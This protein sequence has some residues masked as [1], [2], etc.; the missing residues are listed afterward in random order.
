MSALWRRPCGGTMGLAVAHVAARLQPVQ[1]LGTCSP[2]A[3]DG[4]FHRAQPESSSFQLLT[5][6]SRGRADRAC[7]LHRGVW[8]AW[9]VA[10]QKH[11]LNP[12]PASA[13][14][15]GR[16]LTSLRRAHSSPGRPGGDVRRSGRRG[17][18]PVSWCPRVTCSGQRVG[19]ARSRSQ[20]LT[21]PA[22]VPRGKGLNPSKQQCSARSASLC[23]QS[24]GRT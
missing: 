13:G 15:P 18:L 22:A 2:L 6:Q 7:C 20:V 5:S 1:P 16:V 23:L 11:M 9:R 14:R 8:A 19:A 21:E 4:H 10:F 17:L 3:S 24:A 12:G